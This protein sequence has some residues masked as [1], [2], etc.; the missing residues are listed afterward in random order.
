MGM[1]FG[2]RPIHNDYS[3][4]LMCI[5]SGELVWRLVASIFRFGRKVV[6]IDVFLHVAIVAFFL[7]LN[8]ALI[9]GL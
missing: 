7:Y 9:F 4:V 8:F 3:V 1:F 5:L 6:A 2:S